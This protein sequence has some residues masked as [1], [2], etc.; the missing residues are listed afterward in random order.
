MNDRVRISRLDLEQALGH[1]AA[2]IWRQEALGTRPATQPF[3]IARRPLARR[4]GCSP[5]NIR[6]GIARLVHL[7]LLIPQPDGTFLIGLE[8]R[9]TGMFE[10]ELAVARRLE[11][12]AQQGGFRFGA[13]RKPNPKIEE[14]ESATPGS[15]KSKSTKPFSI[16]SKRNQTEN[17]S[18]SKTEAS[19]VH[20]YA[21]RHARALACTRARTDLPLKL[22]PFSSPLEKKK[23]KVRPEDPAVIYLFFKKKNPRTNE[24]G[25]ARPRGA[26]DLRDHIGMVTDPV[27][28]SDVTSKNS[29]KRQKHNDVGFIRAEEKS[30]RTSK[31]HLLVTGPVS[32]PASENVTAVE[33]VLTEEL[34]DQGGRPIGETV[35]PNQ[36]SETETDE[37]RIGDRDLSVD[38]DFATAIERQLGG[39]NRSARRTK[40]WPNVPP[41]PGIE[42]LGSARTPNP[43]ELDPRDTEEGW[44]RFIAKTWTSAIPFCFR[45]YRDW[46]FRLVLKRDPVTGQFGSAR[47]SKLWG[48]LV[49]AARL[50]IDEEIAPVAWIRWRCDLWRDAREREFDFSRAG[51]PPPVKWVFD[52]RA[53]REHTGWFRHHGNAYAGR[54]MLMGKIARKLQQDYHVMEHDITRLPD[55]AHQPDVDQIVERHFPGGTFDK[56]VKLARREARALQLELNVMAQRGGFA[57]AP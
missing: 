23:N 39:R 2:R 26:V 17:G 47:L 40:R 15:D 4:L 28:I 52:L 55:G 21:G 7:K 41:Y 48:Q 16:D 37:T 24:A 8:S 36:E 12:A 22:S 45:G 5:K 14:R 27:L 3:R 46:T 42:L 57:W 25:L 44:F 33:R 31:S 35:I 9:E 18:K 53:L 50:M 13:G 32:Q 51:K 43:P 56:R 54:Q 30:D 20:A 29:R 6:R 1:E 10:I 49:A 38:A 34:V 11:T 19:R